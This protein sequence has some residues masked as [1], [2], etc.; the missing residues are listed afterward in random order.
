MILLAKGDSSWLGEGSFGQGS[1]QYRAEHAPREAQDRYRVV[2]EEL[3][4]AELCQTIPSVEGGGQPMGSHPSEGGPSGK[5]QRIQ[6]VEVGMHARLRHG[7]R[8]ATRFL[9]AAAALTWALAP[10]GPNPSTLSPWSFESR[11]ISPSASQREAAVTSSSPPPPDGPRPEEETLLLPDLRTFPPA[12]VEVRSQPNGRVLRFSNTVW[13]AGEGPLELRGV[14]D[15][16][17]RRIHVFQ[18]A[19]TARGLTEEWHVGEFLW[20]PTHTHWHLEG[21][22]VYQLWSINQAGEMEVLAASS[23]KVSF[24][25][26]DTDIA[27]PDNDLRP[28]SRQYTGCGRGRQGLSVG[29]GDTYRS[30]LDGQSLP[31]DSVGDGLYAL[32]SIANPEGRLRESDTGNNAGLVY[33]AIISDRVRIVP[34]QTIAKERCLTGGLC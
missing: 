10:L 5:V 18:H 30:Y 20:H 16:A 12:N 27:A 11:A 33:L 32:V 28:P 9:Q 6:P 29:W 7:F 15:V 8:R 24:C 3:E 21:F 2:E 22:A 34:S 23:D 31:L 17:T 25:L 13:N 14:T 4:S 26:I 1:A 19:F